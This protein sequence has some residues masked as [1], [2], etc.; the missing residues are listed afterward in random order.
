MLLIYLTS[1][2]IYSFTLNVRVLCNAILLGFGVG[3][4]E[5]IIFRSWLFRELL[6]KLDFN[7]AIII[8]ALI[9]PRKNK[10]IV[11]GGHLFVSWL[12]NNDVIMTGKTEKVFEGHYYVNN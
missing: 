5:E 2:A 6:E 4:A 9:S 11:D 3:I 12:E 1:S 10:L 8:Q 7:K